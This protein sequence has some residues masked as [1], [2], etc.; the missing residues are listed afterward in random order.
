MKYFIPLIFFVVGL[1]LNAQ[2]KEPVKEGPFTDY[3]PSGELK[4]SGQYENGKRDGQWKTY[5][6]NGQIERLFS[7]NNGRLDRAETTFYDSGAIS[8]KIELIGEIYVVKVFYEDGTLKSEGA[9]KSGYYKSFRPDGSKAVECT[10]LNHQLNG[11][12]RYFSKDGFLEWKVMYHDGYRQGSYVQYYSDGT[13]KLEGTMFKDK[14]HNLEK[15]YDAQNNLVWKGAYKNGA[16]SKKW[17]HYN[18][19]GKKIKRINTAKDSMPFR[20]TVVPDGVIEKVPVFPG[21]ETVFGNRNRI[22]CLNENV[23]NIILSNFNTETVSHL[24]LSGRQRIFVAFKIDK[25]GFLTNLDIKAAHPA[26]IVETRRVMEKMPRIQP[27]YIKGE[28]VT[29]PFSIPI[30]FQIK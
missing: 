30:V 3:Y 20:P 7:Y 23:A 1:Q 18:S 15:R 19:K 6:K 28:P 10:Y 5:H 2:Q 29:V 8:R 26:L 22:K 25:L 17:T 24:G 4:I 14:K 12:W 27:G 11:E 16:F 9:Y 21:C 13:I